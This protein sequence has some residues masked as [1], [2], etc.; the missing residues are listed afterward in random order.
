MTQISTATVT[1]FIALAVVPGR[2]SDYR[3]GR[4]PASHR[5][6]PPRGAFGTAKVPAATTAL[7]PVAIDSETGEPCCVTASQ[8]DLLRSGD[9]T[10]SA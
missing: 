9:G 1:G 2:P 8:A 6:A 4:V 10:P 5:D 3:A 7:V